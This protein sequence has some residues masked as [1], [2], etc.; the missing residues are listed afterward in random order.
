MLPVVETG[1]QRPPARISLKDVANTTAVNLFLFLDDADVV[2]LVI[3]FPF[4][5]LH[6]ARMRRP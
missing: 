5:S 6:S 2:V 4:H 3:V 1:L